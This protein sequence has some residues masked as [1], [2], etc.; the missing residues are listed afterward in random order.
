MQGEG[1]LRHVGHVA[2]PLQYGA[3]DRAG[4]PQ[5]QLLQEGPHAVEHTLAALAVLQFVVVHHVGN[6]RPRHHVVGG[7][8]H[9][10]QRHQHEQHGGVAVGEQVGGQQRRPEQHHA[11]VVGGALADPPRQPYPAGDCREGGQQ[12]GQRGEAGQLGAPVQVLEVERHRAGGH[13]D[14]G[15]EQ[16]PR[17]QRQPQRAHLQRRLVAGEH[18]AGRRP[19]ARHRALAHRGE[20]DQHH[21]RRDHPEQRAGHRVTSSGTG[22]RR[23]VHH[24]GERAG[25]EQGADDR[26]RH[27]IAVEVGALLEAARQVRGERRVGDEHHGVGGAHQA[28]R[29]HHPREQRTLA[30]AVPAH[31]QEHQRHP[32]HHRQRAEQQVGPAPPP[33][34][35]GAVRQR[36]HQRIGNRVPGAPEQQRQ[37]GQRRR[38]TER[39]G[40]EVEQPEPHDGKEQVAAEVPDPIP[41]LGP[42]P[43]RSSHHR[44]V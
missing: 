15:H 1:G 35:G 32:G 23:L 42:Q 38:Q 18:A 10:G 11:G 24:D 5:P 16:R 44:P 22:A 8:A 9:A 26:P 30:P 25:A 14:A 17:K 40:D 43:Q 28:E 7:Q 21:H 2:G 29:E 36:P 20:G 6:D 31:L 4:Q 33:A 13:H 27:P 3:A 19:L 41:H 37:A 34:R 39:V 12:Q